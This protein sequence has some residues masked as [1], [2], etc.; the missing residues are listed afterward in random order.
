MVLDVWPPHP[1][2]GTHLRD[3]LY[4]G[5]PHEDGAHGVVL[6]VVRQATDAVV[7]VTQDL[8]PQLVVFLKGQSMVCAPG[9]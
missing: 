5:K 7:T 1:P 2:R 4:H 3:G 6:P 8:D 9:P